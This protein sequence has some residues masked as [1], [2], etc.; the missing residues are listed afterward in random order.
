MSTAQALVAKLKYDQTQLPK[1]HINT[2]FIVKP[3]LEELAS[4]GQI[5][6]QKCAGET[7]L[8]TPINYYMLSEK[9]HE[10]KVKKLI[11]KAI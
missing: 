7:K 2:F 1:N 5:I 9:L 10:T 11:H 8:R 6:Y 4:V 3:K